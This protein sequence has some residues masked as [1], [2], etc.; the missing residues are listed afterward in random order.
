M[1]RFVVA[2]ACAATIFGCGGDDDPSHDGPDGGPGGGPDGGGPVIPGADPT[3]G[4]GGMA[5][6]GFP[7]GIAAIMRVARQSDGKIVG[8]GGTQESLLIVRV[9]AGG[10]FDASFGADGVVQ[11]PWG[12]ATNGV[13]VGYGCAVQ[14]DGKIVVA[15]RVLGAYDGLTSHE[16]VVRL[17]SDGSLDT[18]F[19]GTGYRIGMAGTAATALAL[20]ESG[21]LVVGGT[22]LERFLP[23]GTADTSFGT[24]GAALPGLGITDLTLD[25]DGNIIAV[26]GKS[27]GRFTSAGAP[28]ATFGTGGIVTVTSDT[29]YDQ[30][31]SVAVQSDG[32]IV[33]GG[34]LTPTGAA[35]QNFW[36]GRFTSTGEPDTS[37]ATTGAVTGDD[38]SGGVAY[39]VGLDATGKVVGSGFATIGGASG[40]NARFDAAGALDTTFG[41]QGLG[42]AGPLE[43]FSNVAL[44]PDGGFAVG[45]AGFTQGAFGYSIAIAHTTAAGAADP[46]FGTGGQI[47]REVGG[48]FDRAHA[49]AFQP[50][51]KILVGGWAYTGGG[52]GVVRF[53]HD[54]TLDTTFADGGTLSRSQNL[55]YVNAL[56]VQPSGKILVAGLSG[57]SGG[58]RQFAVERYDAS[59]TLDASF[60]E[61]GAAGAPIID[62]QDAVGLNMT[63]ADDGTIVLVGQTAT[64]DGKA[65]YGVLELTAEGA[66]KAGFGT[67]GAT[68]TSFGGSYSMATHAVVQADGSA[69]ILGLA[70]GAPT[71]VRFTA[72]GALDASFG[73]L[74]VP[75]SAGMLPFG[76]TQ[77][78]DGALIAVAGS[79]TDG[80]LEVVRYTAGGA[81]D[82][83]FGDGGV[84]T[85]TL[86]G[87]D[88]YGL[89]SFMGVT[90]LPDGAIELGLAGASDDA[91]TESGVLLRL[92]PDGSADESAGTGGVTRLTT[93]RGSSSIN[94]LAVDADGKLVA[95]GRTWTETGG[96]DFMALRFNP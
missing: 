61:G 28:D 64:A 85:R 78:A 8:V 18:S 35:S 92:A 47:T 12:V 10:Q 46:S 71:L 70:N 52:A 39:G 94:A 26:G 88:Y 96:S 7:G 45:G 90:V 80:T 33:V 29:S 44:D 86:G 59:G 3:F 48:S 72:E 11:L 67:A 51:G 37:F 5:T 23:D 58:A 14:P 34:A 91:L 79:Y 62:G 13:Q 1:V 81:L 76:L 73:P 89:Y 50:D 75:D 83:S 9:T 95:V 31:F 16:V 19:A 42:T 24:D 49:L 38:G 55:M 77:Q 41:S 15:A 20:D 30:L 65:E 21:N 68:S 36:I 22:R 87:N 69:V 43:P 63:V 25:G 40:K 54:G 2:L 74:V 27:I 82:D 84:V 53:N 6:A 57:L 60:G 56:A 93:G 17:L 4:N 32:K 66:P